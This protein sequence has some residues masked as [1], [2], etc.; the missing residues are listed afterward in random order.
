M[1]SR[2]AFRNAQALS[3]AARGIQTTA[4][5]L[6]EWPR[7]KRLVDPRPVRHGFI[8]EEWFTIFY[9]KTGATGPYVFVAALS[10]YLVSKEIYVLEH[11]FYNALSLITICV[12]TIKK[13]GPN[14]AKYLDKKVDEQEEEHNSERE[15]E[16]QAHEDAIK[17]METEKWR[18]DGQNMIFDIRKQT[19]LM[20]LEAVYRERA[21]QIY[22]EV[23]KRLDYHSQL[24]TVER[25]IAQKHMVQWIITNVLKSIT[26]EQEKAN[27]QQCIK[28]LEGMA[29]KA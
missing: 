6:S 27:L 25:T 17:E 12:F 11:E 15:Q 4:P 24:D 19:V 2:L 29:V 28:D 8:P 23:K 20:Q 14:V 22:N 1:L 13:F 16:V 5:V 3:V 7:P 10:T 21:M 9:P 18:L 26:P